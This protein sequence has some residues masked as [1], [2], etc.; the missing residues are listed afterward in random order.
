MPNRGSPVPSPRQV[1]KIR[2]GPQKA[3]RSGARDR[4]GP[5]PKPGPGTRPSARSCESRRP[6][7]RTAGKRRNA[8]AL[9]RNP[10]SSAAGLH[11]ADA[12][13]RQAGCESRRGPHLRDAG[14]QES[15]PR[16]V[17]WAFRCTRDTLARPGTAHYTSL[18]KTGAN[19]GVSA[20]VT[21][22]SNVGPQAVE[23]KSFHIAAQRLPVGSA[24]VRRRTEWSGIPHE[25]HARAFSA[26]RNQSPQASCVSALP[27]P[28][29][30]RVRGMRLAVTWGRSLVPPQVQTSWSEERAA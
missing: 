14:R 26:T 15:R 28:E 30:R 7:L 2:R 10:G 4:S 27:L 18:V 17:T 1:R 20:F 12:P 16:P 3:A 22:C 25:E 11:R 29:G 21:S 8:D 6:G 9:V 5:R 13:R 19:T 23:P 24:V